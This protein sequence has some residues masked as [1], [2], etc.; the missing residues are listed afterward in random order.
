[1]LHVNLIFYDQEDWKYSQVQTA[2]FSCS[3]SNQ[4]SYCTRPVTDLDIV[5]L[6]IV[7][8]ILQY[9]GPSLE[10]S[11]LN[12]LVFF[13]YLNPY[14]CKHLQFSG[15]FATTYTLPQTVRARR[16]YNGFRRRSTVRRTKLVNYRFDPCNFVVRTRKPGLN[17]TR[18]KVDKSCHAVTHYFEAHFKFQI[19]LTK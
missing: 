1:M 8:Y 16:I 15:V 4:I 6:I 5:Y 11:K 3:E 14:P 9:R 7:P 2:N 12:Y 17:S 18:M 10:T 19:N 13:R